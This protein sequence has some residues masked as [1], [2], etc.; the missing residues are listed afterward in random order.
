MNKTT[1]GESVQNCKNYSE[2]ESTPFF[3]YFQKEEIPTTC[4]LST[5]KAQEYLCKGAFK[6]DSLGLTA[7]TC[8]AANYIKVFFPPLFFSNPS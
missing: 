4:F 3:T 2:R 6:M 5:G 7:A 8:S 1:S